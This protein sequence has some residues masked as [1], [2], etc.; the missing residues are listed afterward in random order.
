MRLRSAMLCTTLAA[1]IQSRQL[2]SQQTGN[3]AAKAAFG[4][5]V[6]HLALSGD[7]DSAFSAFADAAR[8]TTFGAALYNAGVLASALGRTADA[9]RYWITFLHR[10]S[11]SEFA[12]RARSFLASLR[13]SQVFN[14]DTSYDSA[15]RSARVALASDD[16][17]TTRAL[18]GQA[19][20]QQ[21]MR[22]E[23]YALLARA[24]VTA[25]KTAEARTA[26]QAA[27]MHAPADVAARLRQTESALNTAAQAGGEP[28]ASPASPPRPVVPVTRVIKI[29]SDSRGYRFEPAEIHIPAGSVVRF[30]VA[31][32]GPHIIAFEA[33]GLSE[34]VKAK[35][36]AAMPPGI[37]P[38]A[39]PVLMSAG[40]SYAISFASLP[41]GRYSYHCTPH[42]AMGER[43]VIVVD[44]P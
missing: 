20:M 26:L 41:D 33:E 30:E 34:P 19:I 31:G 12:R 10:D 27:I 15:V 29:Y 22:W 7:L 5:G 18:L 32:S 4:R 36:Q 1:A 39:S 23:A 17:A 2:C 21:P 9:Q 42:L 14:N 16:F 44:R 43:G 37:S 11:T 3:V 13:I 8:D 35:L 24:L 28:L 40:E 25:G 6:A 38:L